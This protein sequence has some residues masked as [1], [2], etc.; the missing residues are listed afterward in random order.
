MIVSDRIHNK[1]R[2]LEF[3]DE[4]EQSNVPI[5]LVVYEKNMFKCTVRHPWNFVSHFRPIPELYDAVQRT[6][7]LHDAHSKMNYVTVY[8][9]ML[10]YGSSV[11]H[12]LCCIVITE[13]TIPVRTPLE[14]YRIATRIAPKCALAP[15]YN[16]SFDIGC[17]PAN[18]PTLDRGKPFQLM[19]NK[20]QALFSNTFIKEALPTLRKYCTYFGLQ[21]T[22]REG[23]TV[24]N[25]RLYEQ[26]QRCTGA[27]AD[28]FWLINSYLL[29][30]RLHNQSRNPIAELKTK[31]MNDTLPTNDDVVVA[32]IHEYRDDV[33]RS[34]VFKDTTTVKNIR[35]LNTKQHT[36]MRY[37]KDLGL[38]RNGC[39]RVNLIHV[40]TYLRT[41]KQNALFFRSVE[42]L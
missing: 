22:P 25:K 37:Y 39:I 1:T 21:Y 40:L 28:E 12:S 8:T 24:I 36:M 11:P 15:S 6:F 20:A 17:P 13:R 33:I 26:W 32:E 30:S 29:H 41:Y 16:V 7:S 2:W 19:N 18:L 4:C 31:H 35:A 38:V 9:D 34:V 27:M 3:I 42:M 10:A 5:D 23:Y 14:I